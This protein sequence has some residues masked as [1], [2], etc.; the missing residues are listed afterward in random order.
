MPIYLLATRG[1]LVKPRKLR[2]LSFQHTIGRE[3][4]VYMCRYGKLAQC[5]WPK[6]NSVRR[7]KHLL[8]LTSPTTVLLRKMTRAVYNL[9]VIKTVKIAKTSNTP[10]QYDPSLYVR[11]VRVSTCSPRKHSFTLSIEMNPSAICSLFY[12]SHSGPCLVAFFRLLNRGAKFLNTI[13]L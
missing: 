13:P 9:P 12:H 7:W 3:P 2:F 1:P 5:N 11:Q 6:T 10:E 4:R 8:Q